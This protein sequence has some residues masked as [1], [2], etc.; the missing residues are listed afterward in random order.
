MLSK[1][2]A[3]TLSIRCFSVQHICSRGHSE[4]VGKEKNPLRWE[5]KYALLEVS[6]KSD[7]EAFR[8]YLK[9]HQQGGS[10]YLTFCKQAAE[11]GV[12]K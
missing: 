8:H 1:V 11:A 4:Y 12:E 9:S 10:D 5:A 7:A 2:C 3:R 6:E